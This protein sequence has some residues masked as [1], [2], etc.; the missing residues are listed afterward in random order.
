M[1]ESTNATARAEKIWQ[2]EHEK[3]KKRMSKNA[4][5]EERKKKE[6][7][8]QIFSINNK[9]SI[10]VCVHYMRSYRRGMS[11]RKN[12]AVEDESTKILRK[13][14]TLNREICGVRTRWKRV[15]G[16]Y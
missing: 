12:M 5:N 7:Q 2:T 14:I 13:K 4:A 6:H 3:R 10:C 11:V 9:S 16:R 15:Q 1:N 8:Q